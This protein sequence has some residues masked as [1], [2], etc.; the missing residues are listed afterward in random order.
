M[1]AQRGSRVTALP[2]LNIGARCDWVI[3]TVTWLLYP[4]ERVPVPIVEEVEWA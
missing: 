1:M 2:I 3:K 4:K